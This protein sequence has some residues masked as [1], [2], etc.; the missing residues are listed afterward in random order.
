[1][2]IPF[3]LDPR[4]IKDNF[5]GQPHDTIINQLKPTRSSLIAVAINL[6]GDFNKSTLIRNA[7]AFNIEQVWICGKRRWDRRGALGS[8]HYVDLQYYTLSNLYTL[9]DAHRKLGYHIVALENNLSRP[10]SPLYT[11]QWHPKT[12]TLFG[13]EG[14]GLSDELLDHCDTTVE[15]PMTGAVR[16]INV[17]TTSGIVMF[18]Y[19]RQRL[20][21]LNAN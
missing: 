19:E 15:I 6:N 13:E 18:E 4:N 9:L 3:N 20:G 12:I 7:S 10:T 14:H 1:M 11:H 5:K 21:S 2:D 8:H 17:G 16:S